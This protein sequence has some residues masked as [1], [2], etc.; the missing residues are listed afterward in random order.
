MTAHGNIL[1]RYSRE[2]GENMN[3]KQKGSR[4]ERALRDVWKKHGYEDAHRSQQYSGKGESSADIE[5]I[6]PRLHIECKTGYSFKQ[7]YNFMS[8]SASDAKEGQIPVCNIKM[9]R[10][11]W[12]WV[13]YLDDGIEMWSNQ[14]E[15]IQLQEAKIVG[16]FRIDDN[17]Y[18]SPRIVGNVEVVVRCKDCK[19]YGD[20][21]I[22]YFINTDGD[23]YCNCGERREDE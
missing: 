13:C 7:I 22:E 16:D 2:N 4:G 10:M 8:Q 18:C 15:T 17:I 20:C 23:G 3:S 14:A 1:T 6:D 21:N 9:D 5:G 11:P 19:R 12:L